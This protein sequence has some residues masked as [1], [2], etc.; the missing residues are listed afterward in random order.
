M[1]MNA[2]MMKKMAAENG[3]MIVPF[4]DEYDGI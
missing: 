1:K 2:K 4:K 3:V